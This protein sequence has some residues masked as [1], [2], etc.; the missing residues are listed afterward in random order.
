MTTWRDLALGLALAGLLPDAALAQQGAGLPL[1]GQQAEEFLRGAEVVGRKRVGRGI[2]RPEKLTLSDGQ[3]TLH[4]IFKTI[5]ER[6]RG[7]THFQEGGFEVDFVDSYKYEIAAYELD[8]LIDLDMVPPT[9]ERELGG[10]RGALQLWVEG[11]ITESERRKRKLAPPDVERWNRQMYT[12]RVF[13]QITF[14]S[15]RANLGNLLSDPEFRVYLIDSS[16]AF[17][18]H[19]ELPAPKDLQRFP[20]ALLARLR[21]LD[22]ATLSR[23]LGSWLSQNEI[24]GLLKRRDL[25]LSLAEQLVTQQGEAAVLF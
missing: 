14:N 20:R 12:V 2:T 17:R 5:D 6:K 24:R 4:A 18:V 22:E 7:V 3:R 19:A 9:V 15:D 25:I 1:R 8:K 21:T 23:A 13:H 16:R 10:Q 11:V